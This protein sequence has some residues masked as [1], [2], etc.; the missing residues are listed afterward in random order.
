[1]N[2]TARAPM[3]RARNFPARDVLFHRA[4]VHHAVVHRAVT[5]AGP[6]TKGHLLS[7][8]AQRLPPWKVPLKTAQIKKFWRGAFLETVNRAEDRD[9]GSTG[10]GLRRLAAKKIA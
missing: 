1:M 6:L 7:R 4:V 2:T 5:S 10:T 3:S 8:N 9:M